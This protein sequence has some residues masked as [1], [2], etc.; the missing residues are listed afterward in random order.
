MGSKLIRTLLQAADAVVNDEDLTTAAE[1]RANGQ[2]NLLRVSIV[3]A[4]LDSL[5]AWEAWRSR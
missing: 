3:A 4:R 5:P 2:L 1:L